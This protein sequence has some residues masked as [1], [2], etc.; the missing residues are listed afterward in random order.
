MNN[1]VYKKIESI[2]SKQKSR[3]DVDWDSNE[4]D[5]SLTER[6]QNLIDVEVASEPFLVKNRIINEISGLGPLDDLLSDADITEILVNNYQEIFYEKNGKLSRYT[7]HFYSENSYVAVLDRLS[8]KCGS[9]LN[10]EKPFVESQSGRL[11][12]TIIFGELSR[13]SSLLSIRVQPKSKWTLESFLEKKWCNESQINQI[14][15]IF[16]QKKNFLVVGGTG[17]GKTS[18]L[19]SLLQMLNK[20]ERAVI[21]EDT[22]ELQ[23]PDSASVSLLTRQ[24]PSRS[25]GDVGMDDLL[26]R[27]LRLRPDRLVI[28]EIRGPEAKSLM[29]AM[30]TGH[31]GSFGSL[32][33]RTALEALLRLEM[34]IQM[35]A[36]QWSLQSIRKLIAMT[37]QNIIVLEKKDG[38]RKLQGIYE[39]S[40]LEETGFTLNQ[41]DQGE[42]F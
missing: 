39:I 37:I 33:A 6:F 42:S 38:F 29:M 19:Q 20:E 13:G 10:R 3:I 17:S 1:D 5:M 34:L 21:I 11:R 35:G 7:D 22:Q 2:F 28:G 23:L 36:P 16:Q 14:K 25:V 15:D 12:I 9:Y 18:F 26:K 27:A 40:S 8:Q 31:D 24:D 4:S 32:H 30:A 41:I